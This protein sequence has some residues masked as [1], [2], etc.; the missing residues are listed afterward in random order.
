MTN[1]YVERTLYF[2]IF[3][4]IITL[5]N[6]TVTLI[7][8]KLLFIIVIESVILGVFLILFAVVLTDYITKDSVKI[9]GKIIEISNNVVTYENERGK[10]KRIKI[11][12]KEDKNQYLVDDDII[13]IESRRAD[14]FKGII[15]NAE[16][17]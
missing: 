3:W 14:I 11:D 4:V 16:N 7:S 13:I 8:T 15:R 12:L 1:K 2:V 17:N 6:L 9:K 10:T 5:V